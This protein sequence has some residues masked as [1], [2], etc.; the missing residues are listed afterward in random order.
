M[1][2]L[3]YAII[4]Y[5]YIYIMYVYGYIMYVYIYIMYVYIYCTCIYIYT[6]VRT[7]VRMYT[8]VYVSEQKEKMALKD[9]KTNKPKQ[10]ARY[11][12][13]QHLLRQLWHCQCTILLR[14]ARSQW[15]ETCHEEVQTWERHQVHCN[16]AQVAV[17]LSREAQAAGH[18]A[19]CRRHQMVQVTV[20]W[21]SQF[22]RAET[23]I[24]QSFVVQQEGLIGVLHQLVEAQHCLRHVARVT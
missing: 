4:V 5:T 10:K 19:H 2:H 3:P 22:Q 9:K 11:S 8:Y 24:V 16:L 18:T 20:S 12:M 17:Q 7:Y 23:N 15:C 13:T 14:T 21:G 1:D 6:Y